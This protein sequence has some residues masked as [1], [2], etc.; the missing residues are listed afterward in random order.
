MFLITFLSAVQW[1]CPNNQ[2]NHQT[3]TVIVRLAAHFLQIFCFVFNIFCIITRLI[4]VWHNYSQWINSS[5][6]WCRSEA[7]Y[8]LINW[9]SPSFLLH[10]QIC[11]W[12]V[13]YRPSGRKISGLTIYSQCILCSSTLLQIQPYNHTSKDRLKYNSSFGKCRQF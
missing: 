11:D 12:S 1:C 3:H 13:P 10:R 5:P 8:K 9:N 6:S 4:N 2:P 7:D